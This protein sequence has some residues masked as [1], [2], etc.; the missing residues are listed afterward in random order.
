M[1]RQERLFGIDYVSGYDLVIH[2][3]QDFLENK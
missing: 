1:T 3:V 2:K